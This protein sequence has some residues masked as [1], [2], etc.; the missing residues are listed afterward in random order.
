[1]GKDVASHSDPVEGLG[2][3]LVGMKEEATVQDGAS[4]KHEV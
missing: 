3:G 2:Q 1:M 4:V